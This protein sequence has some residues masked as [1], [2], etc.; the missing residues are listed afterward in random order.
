[1]QSAI[2]KQ[3]IDCGVLHR[4]M[5]DRC[6]PCERMH[7]EANREIKDCP[8]CGTGFKNRASHYCSSGC[9]TSAHSISL[10]AHRLVKK[11]VDSCA[12]PKASDFPCADC[13]EKAVEYDHRDYTKPLAVDPV[14]RSCNTKRGPAHTF[15]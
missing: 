7:N 15:K 3:C 1:M 5:V 4:R 9:G 14:C 11:A 10:I 13:G 8:M 12:I 6:I 2:K